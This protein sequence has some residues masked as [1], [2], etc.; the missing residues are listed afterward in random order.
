MLCEKL[1]SEF[2]LT[3]RAGSVSELRAGFLKFR[4]KF[5][6][7]ILKFCAGAA[8]KLRVKS[9]K[10]RA[11]SGAEH[12]KF[13]AASQPLCRRPDPHGMLSAVSK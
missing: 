10:F 11:K 4:V 9:L 2:D 7:E 13:C 12:L 5:E 3:L 8:F 1:S 6:A